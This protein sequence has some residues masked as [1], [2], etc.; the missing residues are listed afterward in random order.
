MHSHETNAVQFHMLCPYDTP[1]FCT[2]H[3]GSLPSR[4]NVDFYEINIITGSYRHTYENSSSLVHTGTLLFYKP[5]QPHALLQDSKTSH[6]YSLI[7][8]SSYFEEYCNRHLLNPEQIL[9]STFIET[10]MPG[11]QFTYF[12]YLADSIV[13]SPIP[14]NFALVEHLL[15]NL[16][17]A[18]MHVIPASTPGY[19]NNVYARDLLQR[20]NS[21]QF[22]GMDVAD[23]YAYYPLSQTALINDFKKLTGYTIVQYRNIKRMEYAADFLIKSNYSVTAIANTLNIS[24]LGYFSQQFK[25]QFGMTPTEYQQQHRAQKKIAKTKKSWE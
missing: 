11:V 21:F 6:H 5:G 12:S 14:E 22:L 13:S 17:F 15:S 19:S 20:L 1:V 16:L 8:K 4:C 2:F 3:P 9:S 10:K 7:V 23:M 25:K 18:C 24:S